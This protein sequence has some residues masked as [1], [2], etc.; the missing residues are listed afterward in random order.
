MRGGMPLYDRAVERGAGFSGHLKRGV[1]RMTLQQYDDALSDWSESVKADPRS[2]GPHILRADLLRRLHR[3]DDA[4]GEYDQAVALSNAS[5]DANAP[6]I[7]MLRAE[8]LRETGDLD[9]SAGAYQILLASADVN[10]SARAAFLLAE[11]Q[12]AKGDGAEARAVVDDGLKR[13]P[14][15]PLGLYERGVVELFVEDRP[16]PAADDLSRSLDLAQKYRMQSILLNAG[17]EILASE[18]ADDSSYYSYAEPF[19]P[20][21][22]QAMLL[23]DVARSRS[24]QDGAVELK[25]NF[26]DVAFALRPAGSLQAAKLTR[27]PA[28]I[29]GY[30]L[31]EVTAGDLVTQAEKA[32]R[33]TL[34]DPICTANLFAGIR[35]D[36]GAE[37]EE[38]QR[39]LS[40]ASAKCPVWSAEHGLAATELHRRTQPHDGG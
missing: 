15:D 30:Y 14:D 17:V 33:L 40:S 22:Y 18:R 25:K 6:A 32:S 5:G 3:P 27:W 13:W 19:L 34:I 35:H 31:N 23:L 29:V 2:P 1:C 4:R 36:I 37:P 7:Q 16:E 8:F 28:P 10:V 38:T 26:D 20:R 21:A 11:I 12:I 39:E 24:Q 9:A